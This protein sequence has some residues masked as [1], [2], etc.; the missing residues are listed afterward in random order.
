MGHDQRYLR[1]EPEG[2]VCTECVD[3]WLNEQKFKDTSRGGVI[4]PAG[5]L[6]PK[7]RS[8]TEVMPNRAARRRAR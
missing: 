4:L 8:V 5:A 3:H 6:V 1:K 7:Q 2:W